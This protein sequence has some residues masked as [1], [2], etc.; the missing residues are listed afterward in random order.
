MGKKL[1]NIFKG[2]APKNLNQTSSIINNQN[3]D[4]IL[5]E[6]EEVS[7]NKQIKNIFS[8][9]SFVYKADT[10]ITLISG[11]VIN[12]TIIGRTNDSLITIDDE[13]IEVSK[14]A[15]IELV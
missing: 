1:P 15:K 13:L 4:I 9:D 5:E 3:E 8:S 7:V 10:I 11:E 12:K 6:I 14:I 2:K